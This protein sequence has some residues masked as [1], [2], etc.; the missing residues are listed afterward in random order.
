MVQLNARQFELLN[1]WK[2]DALAEFARARYFKPEPDQLGGWLDTHAPLI[3][4][5][6][7][8]GLGLSGQDLLFGT[9]FRLDDRSIDIDLSQPVVYAE[10]DS[11]P[12]GVDGFM[13]LRYAWCYRRNEKVQVCGIRILI[14]QDGF[15]LLWSPIGV[16]A[17]DRQTVFL[18]SGVVDESVLLP[19]EDHLVVRTIEPGPIPMGPFVYVRAADLRISTVLC[20]CMPSQVYEYESER[21]YLLRPMQDLR[22]LGLFPPDR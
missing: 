15:P 9:P 19:S 4:Q 12:T 1:E 7:D 13:E 21:W 11:A 16:G 14:D 18:S 20:R 2:R 6:T 5:Q 17:A 8:P 3:V 22:D 10:Q